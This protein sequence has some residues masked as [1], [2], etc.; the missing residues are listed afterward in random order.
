MSEMSKPLDMDRV[1]QACRSCSVSQL[2]LPAGLE[3]SELE[4]LESALEK[5]MTLHRGESLYTVGDPLESLFA[6]RSGC[7]KTSVLS[8][9]GV[10]QIIGFALPGELL[11]L[12]ALSEERH[13][14]SAVAL[15]TTA[16]CVLPFA[17][18]EALA[19][20]L[21]SLNRQLL[22]IM[23]AEIS[24]EQDL[25]SLL[26][27]K[28]A[29]ERLAAFLDNLSRRFSDRGYSSQDFRLYM[30][31][32]EMA[33]YLGMTIETVSRTLSAWQREGLIHIESKALSILDR[34][35]LRAIAGNCIRD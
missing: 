15:D 2:C 18:I 5:K 17:N 12:D 23:G 21:P 33:N 14:C 27:N 7:M 4:R 11:G 31:R 24:R 28:R 9:D 19:A 34:D 26:A 29:S 35:G 1:R 3:A 8:S 6:V 10:E 16:I 13:Q 22:K 20:E 32:Q 30:S 25:L